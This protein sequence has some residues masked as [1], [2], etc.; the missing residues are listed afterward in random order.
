MAATSND[1]SNGA[2]VKAGESL[3]PHLE[4]LDRVMK[5]PVIEAA[6]TQS[7]GYYDKMRGECWKFSEWHAT[8][9]SNWSNCDDVMWKFEWISV[10][11]CK[12]HKSS[13]PCAGACGGAAHGRSLCVIQQWT[14]QIQLHRL[15]GGIFTTISG[16][17]HWFVSCIWPSYETVIS[18]LIDASLISQLF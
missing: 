17:R 1:K 8:F 9:L 5:L 2:V 3:L 11:R 10:P 15:R 18:M 14:F 13:F 6:W 7:Q 12:V 16:F 4:S